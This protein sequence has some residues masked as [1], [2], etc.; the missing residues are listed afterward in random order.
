[1]NIVQQPKNKRLIEETNRFFEYVEDTLIPANEQYLRVYANALDNLKQDFQQAQTNVQ[2]EI[3]KAIANGSS[4]EDAYECSNMR[5]MIEQ[6]EYDISEF[7]IH[8]DFITY[9]MSMSIVVSIQSFVEGT[10]K[11]ICRQKLKPKEFRKLMSI[12]ENFIQNFL[13]ILPTSEKVSLSD[14]PAF[15]NL[16]KHR[17]DYVHDQFAAKKFKTTK[18]NKAEH[19]YDLENVTIQTINFNETT[20]KEYMASAKVLLVSVIEKV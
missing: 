15:E 16:K 10:L 11:L 19:S 17:N 7:E 5:S 1:M 13:E 12:K 20:L 6:Y 4:K 14:F 8:K 9:H 18:R 3:D 2:Q